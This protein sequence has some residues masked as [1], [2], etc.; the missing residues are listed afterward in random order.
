MSAARNHFLVTVATASRPL[1]NTTRTR[2]IGTLNG[3]TPGAVG[4]PSGGDWSSLMSP[5]CSTV[6]APVWIAMARLT[7]LFGSV[8][9]GGVLRQCGGQR[10]HRFRFEDAAR[11]MLDRQAL[12]AQKQRFLVIIDD[13]DRLASDEMRQVFLLVKALADFPN[14][15]Y[16]LHLVTSSNAIQVFDIARLAHHEGAAILVILPLEEG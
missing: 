3:F 6:P 10:R 16:V 1:G 13:I 14:T 9:P 5:V 7:R 8:Q 4:L 15:V 11:R 12:A 2:S